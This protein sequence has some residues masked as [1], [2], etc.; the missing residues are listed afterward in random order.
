MKQLSSDE[1]RKL[2]V[3]MLIR[4]AG[5][6]DANSLCYMLCGGTLLGA[7]RHK[8]FIP[9]DDDI[10][11]MMPRPDYD[12]FIQLEVKR[13]RISDTIEV[14]DYR[15][16]NSLVPYTKLSDNRTYIVEENS[17]AEMGVWIDIFPIDG[18]YDSNILNFFHYECARILRKLVE[19]QIFNLAIDKRWITRWIRII[20][21]PILK[22]IPHKFLC[23]CLDYFSKMKD[24]DSS[25][26]VGRVL[27]G[28]GTRQRTERKKI[29]KTVKVEFEG[30]QFDAPSN[31]HELLSQIYGDYMKLPPL[32]YRVNHG[33]R[34]YWKNDLMIGDES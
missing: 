11:L 12:R 6:C 21:S 7:I 30:Y 27:M 26:L 20:I 29:I 17:R 3:E 31:Y 32:E 10:D 2:Q 19:C 14:L 4:F 24:F 34:A 13:K 22:H 25:K 15:L 9:W 8:G 1:Y 16:G 5:Y 23:T 18:N 28:Y 33:I